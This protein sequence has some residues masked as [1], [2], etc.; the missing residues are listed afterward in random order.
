MAFEQATIKVE[1][2][3]EFGQLKSAV[4]SAFSAANVQKYLKSVSRAGLRIRD[5][6]S[7]LSRG[8]IEQ[9][10]AG[11][12]GGQT[13]KALYSALTVSDQAQMKEFYLFKL[14]EV[15]PELRSK[16]QKIYQYY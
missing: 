9:V 2:E 10:S 13:A 1:K 14:E 12:L 16:F 4:S 11:E 6:D 3:A 8:L 5:L 15:S 7:V